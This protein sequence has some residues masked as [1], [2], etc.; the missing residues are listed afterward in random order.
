MALFDS[1]LP[2]GDEHL[3][4]AVALDQMSLELEVVAEGVGTT[5]QPPVGPRRPPRTGEVT[6]GRLGDLLESLVDE[7]VD[8]CPGGRLVVLAETA[9]FGIRSYLGV[10]V[11]TRSGAV[12]GT[13]CGASR[14]PV[15][16]ASEVVETFR[17]MARLMP[18][19]TDH[20]VSSGG[21]ARQQP[22]KSRMLLVA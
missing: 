11:T 8:V 4:V 7:A 20:R 18:S 2:V 9:G 5:A 17:A 21:G 22:R 6:P 13:L 12:F 19:T 15:E 16:V 10:P 1:P 3:E 14:E